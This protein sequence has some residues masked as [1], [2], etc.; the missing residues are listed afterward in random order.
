MYIGLCPGLSVFHILNSRASSNQ[1]RGECDKP[2]CRS[3]CT[4]A[5]P[6]V[7]FVHILLYLFPGDVSFTQVRYVID[8]R[9]ALALTSRLQYLSMFTTDYSTSHG[10]GVL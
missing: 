7:C 2:G 3:Y 6:W 5:V 9:R 1:V 8:R 4:V 10:D